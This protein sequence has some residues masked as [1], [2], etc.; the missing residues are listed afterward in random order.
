MDT[1]I[2]D[3]F[4]PFEA[5]AWE[6]TKDA[7]NDFIPPLSARNSTV[8]KT[9]DGSTEDSEEPWAYFE[10]MKGQRNIIAFE[11][12][13]VLAFISYIP[14]HDVETPDGIL[15]GN[16]LS[17]II[18]NKNTRN[19]GLAKRLYAEL[20]NITE[21]SIITRTWSTNYAHLHILEEL[22]FNNCLTLPDDRGAGIDTVYYERKII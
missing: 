19:K 15:H 22:G 14:N 5:S 1:I 18:T 11:G 7:N 2:L 4:G 17:T 21:D 13:D 6:L 16:Y 8:Q 20:I 10:I 12:N 3:G 9:L